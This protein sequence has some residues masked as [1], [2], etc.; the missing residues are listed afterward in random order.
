VANP[1]VVKKCRGVFNGHCVIQ[2]SKETAETLREKLANTGAR[3]IY[4]EKYSGELLK[5]HKDEGDTCIA[6]GLDLDGGS[7]VDTVLLK[8]GV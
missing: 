7:Y 8:S 2:S 1:E 4:F 5:Y 6:Y 3:L